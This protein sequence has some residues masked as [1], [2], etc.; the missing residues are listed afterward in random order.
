M[1]RTSPLSDASLGFSLG[2]FATDLLLL[3]LYY[4]SFGGPEMGVH[5]LAALASVAAAALQ[6]GRGGAK[7]AGGLRARAGWGVWAMGDPRLS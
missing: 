5:H 6:V 1:L 2:Y 7:A 3:V 4:P